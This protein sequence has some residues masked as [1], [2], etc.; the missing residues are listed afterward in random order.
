MAC[1]REAGVFRGSFLTILSE[2]FCWSIGCD[3]C[4]LVSIAVGVIYIVE[5]TIRTK[6]LCNKLFW[7]EEWEQVD[8]QNTI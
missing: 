1:E 8:E 5:S 7:Q 2:L 6:L 4:A 3:F